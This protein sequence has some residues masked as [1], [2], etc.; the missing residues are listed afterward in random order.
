MF[1]G[2]SY[3]A[4]TWEGLLLRRIQAAIVQACSMRWRRSRDVY[5][6]RWILHALYVP[7]VGVVGHEKCLL[8]GLCCLNSHQALC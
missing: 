3:P 1:V 8:D 4:Y 6:M 2:E 7:G 5:L